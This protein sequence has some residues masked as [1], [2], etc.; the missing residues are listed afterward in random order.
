M[1]KVEKIEFD[2]F[3]VV[4][5]PENLRFSENTL[6]NYLQ[7][8]GGYYDNFSYYLALA[9]KNLQNKE[10]Q[11][12][13]LYNDRF[14][15]AKELGSS[16]KLAEAK[17][18]ADQDVSFLKQECIEA[19][20]IV[21]RIKYHLKTWDKNHD[22]AQSMG[23]MLSKQ[24]DKLSNDIYGSGGFQESLDKNVAE[25]VSS[26]SKNEEKGFDSSIGIEGLV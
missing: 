15:E 14:I 18:K 2:K 21:N 11:Y 22:N 10:A 1:S 26:F 5:D 12:E 7:S 9:E 25:T 20:Y 19:K 16:D 23:Y 4:I 24:I 6:S 17:S 3:M 13:K 8:E